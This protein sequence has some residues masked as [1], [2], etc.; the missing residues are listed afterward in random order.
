MSER[1]QK[2]LAGTGLA[3]RRAIEEMIREGRV[4]VNG[5][6]AMIGQKIEAGDQIKVDGRMV[7]ITRLA[8]PPRVLLYKK[9]VGEMVTRDDPEGR[10]TVFRNLPKLESGRWIAVGRLDINTSGLLLLTNDG[11]LARRLMHPSF[12]IVRRYAVRV[13]GDIDRGI[14]AR[15]RAGVE[16]DDGKARFDSIERGQN[17]DPEDDSANS[18]WTV[19]VSEGRKRVVRRLFESQELKVSRL[20]RTAYGPVQLGRGIKAGSYREAEPEELAALFEAV[21]LPVPSASSRPRPEWA[22]PRGARPPRDTP[23]QRWSPETTAASA[24]RFTAAAPSR[25]R[26]GAA[27]GNAGRDRTS[28]AVDTAQAPV[29]RR[30]GDAAAAPQPVGPRGRPMPQTGS[31]RGPRVTPST[32][33]LDPASAE[34]E[35]A[36][37][38][39]AAERPAPRRARP[40]LSPRGPAPAA[41]ERP[42]AQARGERTRSAPSATAG[43]RADARVGG[44][45]PA[46]PPA[47]AGGRPSGKPSAG[48]A[49]TS[50]PRPPRPS[51]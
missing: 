33:R 5:E 24:G 17:E 29:W 27:A 16:L 41:A 40:P 34:G 22:A 10:Q 44:E 9:K 3:S 4:L 26:A 7:S 42:S 31:R 47:R 45:R 1:L 13:L 18:W 32:S 43:G 8:G 28:T 46:R 21:Q 36:P 19:S 2:I 50:K 20:M 6:T 38:P 48:A 30:S 51:R 11:E 12:G 14:L 49:S 35:R 39:A 23:R 37:A 15:L 25:S